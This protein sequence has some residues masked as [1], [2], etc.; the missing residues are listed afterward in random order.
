MVL[1]LV[2]KISQ[3]VTAFWTLRL[4]C[5]DVKSA[6]PVNT[7]PKKNHILLND[8][9]QENVRGEVFKGTGNSGQAIDENQKA[10]GHQDNS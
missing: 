10:I 4:F 7:P 6:P 3:T 5:L 8:A 9:A 2:R 1:L